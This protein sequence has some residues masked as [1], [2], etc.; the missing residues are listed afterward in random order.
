MVVTHKK[1][2]VMNNRFAGSLV[3]LCMAAAM[4]AAAGV[5][6]V[7]GNAVVFEAGPNQVNTLVINRR[8]SAFD[9][10]TGQTITGVT[11]HDSTANILVQAPC[12]VFL[13]TAVC[14]V[15]QIDT[16]VIHLGDGNDRVSQT[17]NFGGPLLRMIVEGGFGDDTITGGPA[18][19]SLDGGAG[20]DRIDGDD[21]DDTIT[22][23]LGD[24]TINGGRNNDHLFGNAGKDVINGDIGDDEI[25]GGIGDDTIDG[26]QGKDVIR[27][28]AGGDRVASRDGFIDNVNCGI[29]N[30]TLNG[31][32]NDIVKRCD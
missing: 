5:V 20:N 7:S 10:S 29:G 8:G 30:D 9:P 16:A 23:G 12:R 27:G 32:A 15:Q 1:G 22:G 3:I 6:S 25:D 4:P 19:D 11:I 28:D 21:G 18:G 24:D 13:G 2:S 17:P 14:D 31:D 26:G